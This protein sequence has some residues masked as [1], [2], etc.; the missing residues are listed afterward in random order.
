M[1]IIKTTTDINHLI[2]NRSLINLCTM[3]FSKSFGYAL[4]GILYVAVLKERNER[5]R[6]DEIANDLQ[7]PRHFLG[8]IMKRLVK[9]HILSSAQGQQGG[10]SINDDTLK[11]PLLKIVEITEGPDKFSSCVLGMRKCNGSTPCPLH[12]HFEILK[13]RWLRLLADYTIESL[14][15]KDQDDFIKSIAAL[16]HRLI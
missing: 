15:Q 4:R 16:D 13:K 12:N 11:T 10:F 2:K 7:I 14:L 1:I 8:K 3:F 6:L 5:V 9:D